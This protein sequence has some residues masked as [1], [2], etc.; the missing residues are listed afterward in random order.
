MFRETLAAFIF[1]GLQLL[2]IVRAL[3]A[4]LPLPRCLRLALP[5]LR[6]DSADRRIASSLFLV[7]V[8]ELLSPLSSLL[9]SR[10][11]LLL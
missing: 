7:S 1:G 9:S 8:Q 5:V 4:T 6:S 3:S 11:S 10:M 2:H